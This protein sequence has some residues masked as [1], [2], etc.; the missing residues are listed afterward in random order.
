MLGGLVFTRLSCPLLEDRRS[1]TASLMLFD[2][3]NF[4]I[5]KSYAEEVDGSP[6]EWVVLTEV[7]AAPLNYGYKNP[8]WWALDTLNGERI[9][10]LRALYE[11]YM[12][13]DGE[14]LEFLF[15][16]GGDAI[17]LD[18]AQCRQ[19]EADILRMHAIPSIVS[20]GL[21]CTASPH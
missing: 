7:L 8:T 11:A 6:R 9:H 19:S 21:A 18:A 12:R 4:Q 13:F 1:K 3:V 20:K 15:S 10:S 14:F 17:V 5:A 16:H 2:L